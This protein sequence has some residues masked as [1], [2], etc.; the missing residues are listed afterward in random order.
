MTPPS[1]APSQGW[2]VGEPPGRPPTAPD[3]AEQ[4]SARREA[5]MEVYARYG[6]LVAEEAAAVLRGDAARVEALEGER[7]AL[8][9]HYE[10][11]RA[12]EPTGE[13]ID[14]RETLADALL[15]AD[16][17]SAVDLTLRRELTRVA[18]GLRAL[19][20]P[21]AGEASAAPEVEDETPTVGRAV[22]ALAGALID[23]RTQ[24]VGGAL[25]GYYPGIAGGVGGAEIVTL[26]DD[27]GREPGD[28]AAA[29]PEGSRLDV[30]F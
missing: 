25:S 11:L 23:A 13:A 9:E 8:A 3:G 10:E 16:H 18:E 12:A 28:D 4:R 17:Q 5:R 6:S 19:P 15:E 20:A 27:A 26:Y 1:S 22:A 2:L 21:A 29:G 24:G 14:F 7:A 30:R